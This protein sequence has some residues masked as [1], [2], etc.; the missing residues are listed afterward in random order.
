[1][2]L[3]I[4]DDDPIVV[5]S[6]RLIIEGGSKSYPETIT[7]VGTGKNG[8]E[9]VS[10]Y[11]K[12]HPDILLLDIRME[13]MNGLD[14]AREILH[15]DP[16]AHILFLTT[17]LDEDYIVEALRLGARGYLRKSGVES[18]LPSLY[19]VQNGHHVYGDEI[20]EKLPKLL[21]RPH[22]TANDPFSALKEDEWNIVRLVS[23][24]KSNK[25]IAD[26][27]HFSEGT[28]RNYLSIIM[29]K[30]QVQGRTQLAIAFYKAGHIR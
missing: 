9:A 23:E 24:G 4:V 5:E 2:N 10:L 15:S 25:E 18:L 7:V 16:L 26:A 17:F 20:V 22:H 27:L 14:A 3:V 29:E 8:K 1:M 12:Y 28:I 19:A 13:G 6:L 30:C 21:E 11:A